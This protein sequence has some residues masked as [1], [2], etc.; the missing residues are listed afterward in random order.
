M[1]MFSLPLIV[2]GQEICRIYIWDNAGDFASFLSPDPWDTRTVRSADMI[3]EAIAGIYRFGLPLYDSLEITGPTTEPPPLD[4]IIAV[5]PNMIFITFGWRGSGGTPLSSSIIDKLVAYIDS[6]YADNVHSLYIEGNDIGWEYG[7]T[8][9]THFSYSGL[10][11]RLGGLLRSDEVIPSSILRGTAGSL[12]SGLTLWY[13][14]A[15]A[16]PTTSMDDIIIGPAGSP[17]AAQA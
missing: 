17:F 1:L 6:S 5:E 3:R 2:N 13:N 16:G 15:A 7:D 14:T 9:A 8:S 4:G 12:A 10:F 11:Q